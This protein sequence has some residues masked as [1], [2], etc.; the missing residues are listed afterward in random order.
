MDWTALDDGALLRDTPTGK[1]AVR[2]FGGSPWVVRLN[3]HDESRPPQL[4]HEV[5]SSVLD[6]LYGKAFW[7]LDA[8]RRA[9]ER[10]NDAVKASQERARAD[11]SR[12]LRRELKKYLWRHPTAGDRLRGI[13]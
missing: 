2:E 11:S 1:L 10:M 6:A 4:L 12:S 3:M 8:H 13:G 7:E 5:G 9:Y